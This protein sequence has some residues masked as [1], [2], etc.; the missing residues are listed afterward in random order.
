MNDLKVEHKD[1]PEQGQLDRVEAIAG[2]ITEIIKLLG[3]DPSREGLLKTPIRAAKALLFST[4]GY[5]QDADSVLR[6][7]IFEHAGSRMIIVR[8]IEFYSMCEHHILPFLGK[9]SIGYIPDGKMAG[10]SKLARLVN[11]YAR[12]LQVQERMTAQICDAVRRTLNAKGVMVLV[13]AGHLCMKMRG[14]EKQ[15]SA[16]AT[17]DY[18]G[19]FAE[20]ASLRKEF[21]E[22]LGD[23]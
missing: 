5:S 23:K 20:D 22:A 10:L 14:V 19:L 1:S 2:H 8:D 21:F 6:Q 9:V 3:E 12:R 4:S 7:A 17:V 16:T 15:E 11:V 13:E 18:S